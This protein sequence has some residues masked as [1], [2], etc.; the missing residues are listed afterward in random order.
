MSGILPHA[1]KMA[2]DNI[3]AHQYCGDCKEAVP[4]VLW[5]VI[6]TEGVGLD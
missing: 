6:M 4:G 1:A 5:K 3:N 2:P